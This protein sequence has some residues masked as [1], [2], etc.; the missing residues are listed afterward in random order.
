MTII[1]VGFHYVHPF[2]PE[3]ENFAGMSFGAGASFFF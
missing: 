3:E 2:V 1:E